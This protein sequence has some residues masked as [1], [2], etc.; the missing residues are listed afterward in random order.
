MV[1]RKTLDTLLFDK[2]VDIAPRIKSSR[3]LNK[4]DV[5]EDGVGNEDTK[6]WR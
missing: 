6:I 5:I 3:F 2:I 1:K 4:N